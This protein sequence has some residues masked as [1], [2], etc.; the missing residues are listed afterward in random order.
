[1]GALQTRL[2][3]RVFGGGTSGL[4]G[5]SLL[6]WVVAKLRDGRQPASE[7]IDLAQLEPGETYTI[8]TRPAPNRKVRKALAAEADAERRLRRATRRRRSSRRPTRQVAYLADVARQATE[9]R[10]LAEAEQVQKLKPGR[11]IRRVIQ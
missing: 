9:A 7:L 4:I 3:A 6:S 1:M 11:R 10:E 5:A 2:V 8:T